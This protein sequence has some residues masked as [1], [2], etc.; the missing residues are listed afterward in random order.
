MLPIVASVLLAGC[1]VSA[2][3]RTHELDAIQAQVVALTPPTGWASVGDV[4][5]EC[6]AVNLDCDNTSSGRVFRSTTTAASCASLVAWIA[7]TPA[8]VDP[9]AV[10]RLDESAPPSVA[11]CVTE[12]GT[13]GR[14]LVTATG[15]DGIASDDQL[16]WTLT[17]S[18][19]D[20]GLR[21]AAILGDPPRPLATLPI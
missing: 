2:E 8:F 21:L 19:V 6:D 12:I 3:S 10:V 17:T 18:T 1:A 13:R 15:P 11:D 9:V 14:Y 4:V 16:A 20:G 5:R 7:A